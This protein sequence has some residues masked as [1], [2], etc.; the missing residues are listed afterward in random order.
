MAKR[1]RPE[2]ESLPG[3]EWRQCYGL[4]EGNEVSN[5]GR[6]RCWRTIGSNHGSI[7]SRPRLRKP[8]PVRKGYLSFVFYVNKKPMLRL[9][10]RLVLE[11]FVGPRSPG[12]ACRHMD[13]D[14]TN[15]ALSNLAW[16]TYSENTQDQI[17]HGTDTR[18]ERNG[19]AKLSQK[20]ADEIRVSHLKATY[21]SELYGVS[22]ATISRIRHGHRYAHH[23]KENND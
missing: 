17:R 9:A 20:Q 11:A 10:H 7:A 19:G 14:P 1:T 18:G 12:E 3:E 16:G 2:F 6:V 15:N 23:M 21:L 5:L 8:V 22:Q 13:G 4:S